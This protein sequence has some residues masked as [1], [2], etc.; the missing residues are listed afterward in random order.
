[1]DVSVQ[2]SECLLIGKPLAWQNHK[3]CRV[4]DEPVG[5][6]NVKQISFMHNNNDNENNAN[7]EGSIVVRD[8]GKDANLH[9]DECR[10]NPCDWMKYGPCILIQI[11]NE[12][13]GK[14][15]DRDGNIV[16]DDGQARIGNKQLSFVDCSAFTS[17]KHGYLGKRNRIPI[18]KCIESGIRL[19][20]PDNNNAYVGFRLA[21]Q[22]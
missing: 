2:S 7:E 18:P 3:K 19:N 15:V 6:A 22:D 17:M 4:E 5:A 11:N 9:C 21:E 1:M 8:L 14:F 12:Y 16:D 13:A 20:Y 10:Q